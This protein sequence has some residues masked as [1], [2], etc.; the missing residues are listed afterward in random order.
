MTLSA[1]ITHFIV[2][3]AAF[4]AGS[5]WGWVKRDGAE[6]EQAQQRKD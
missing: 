6:R 3:L 4:G 5:V 2:F 1:Y